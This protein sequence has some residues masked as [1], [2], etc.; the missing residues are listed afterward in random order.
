[1]EQSCLS[2]LAVLS[3]HHDKLR[4]HLFIIIIIIITLHIISP[5]YR[6]ILLYKNILTTTNLTYFKFSDDS[7]L[8]YGVIPPLAVV[9]DTGLT[10]SRQ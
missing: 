3:S 1:M 8:R 6:N 10:T 4:F 9:G 5:W 2:C 7:V